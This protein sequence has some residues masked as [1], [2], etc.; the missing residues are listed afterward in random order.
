MINDPINVIRSREN[1]QPNFI[2]IQI[3]EQKKSRMKTD[4]FW[5]N[6]NVPNI[7]FL[8]PFANLWRWSSLE[9]TNE[10]KFPNIYY[11]ITN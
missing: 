11:N 9:L 8:F 2:F 3:F 10:Q 5:T 4:W 7:F 6:K 1:D